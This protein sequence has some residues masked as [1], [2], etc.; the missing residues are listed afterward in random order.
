MAHRVRSHLRI[1]TETYDEI[2]RRFIPGYEAMLARAAAEVAAVSPA[3]ALD[4]GA[5]TGALAAA[6][7]ERSE[8]GRV[9]LLDV[10]AEMLDQARER[11]GHHGDR[12]G[13][14]L[15]SYHDPLPA[16]DAVASSLA[17]HH[18]PTLAMK[19]ALFERVHD[20]LPAGGVLVNADA[21]MPE[22]RA[23]RER[24]FRFWADHLVASGIDEAQAWRHFED[25][26]EEDTYLPLEDELAA[27]A[28]V[29]FEA[30]Q[31]WSTGPIGVV[32]A[33]KG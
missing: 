11:L 15:G 32:V 1:A 20:A 8:I 18:I 33:R 9:E 26:S 30:E 27:L 23:G 21:N 3:L 12:V 4:V 13:F 29:G 5:G 10:D 31:V 16:C 22:D 7:L 6:L 14:T 24:L 25:W 2:I 17:L 19:R 28:D